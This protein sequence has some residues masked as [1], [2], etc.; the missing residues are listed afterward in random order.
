[1]PLSKEALAAAAQVN[2]KF[3]PG[4]LVI[5][6]EVPELPTLS[7]GSLSVDIALGGGLPANQWSEFVGTESSSKTSLAYLTIA[8]NQR[9]DPNFTTLWVGSEKYNGQWAAKFGVDNSRVHLAS[10]N[11]META[12]QIMVDTAGAKGHDLIVLDSYP[13]L[14]AE[15][16]NEK[17]MDEMVVGLGARRTNQ[18]FRKVGSTMGRSLLDVERPVYGIFINQWRKKIGNLGPRA[19][20]NTTP[21]GEGKNYS[22][23]IRVELSRTDFIDEPVPGKNMKRRVG[24]V[25]KVKTFKNK[26]TSPYKVGGYDLYIANAPGHGFRAGEIDVAKDLTT[27]GVLYDVIERGGA[28]WYTLPGGER[29]RSEDA[30]KARIREDLDIQELLNAN[31]R[32]VAL[33]GSDLGDAQEDI[34]LEDAA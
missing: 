32:A 28:G 20:P 17:D 26:Q 24:V 15:S 9:R 11:Q 21:G 13:A 14:I 18:F 1:M 29:I 16:E 8:T 3:G 34:P 25:V 19:N 30:L 27:M 10:T 5:A 33:G 31:I 6:S 22:F 7:T 23:Y 4:T 12:Y 2:K